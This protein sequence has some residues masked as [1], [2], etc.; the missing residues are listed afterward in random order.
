MEFKSYYYLIKI[1]LFSRIYRKY[2][3]AYQ[4][5]SFRLR[6]LTNSIKIFIKIKLKKE[7]SIKYD[8]LCSP[9]TYGDF[10]VVLAFCRFLSFFSKNTKLMIVQGNHR[11]DWSS[12]SKLDRFL[13][14]KD[15]LE[16]VHLLL[17]NTGLE[18]NVQVFTPNLH[19]HNHVKSDLS[20]YKIIPGI[21]QILAF[22]FRKNIP[23]E[24][25][26]RKKDFLLQEEKK[27][28][29]WHVRKG[30]WEKERNATESQLIMDYRSLRSLFPNHKIV[31][32]SSKEGLD[33]T[34]KILTSKLNDQE[35][36]K[37]HYAIERQQATSYV[38]CIPFLVNCDFYFQR[39]G[40]GLGEVIHLTNVSHLIIE[41]FGYYVFHSKVKTL[42]WF[43]QY[44]IRTGLTGQDDPIKNLSIEEI[45]NKFDINLN[46]NS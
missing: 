6:I 19:N 15:Q 31:V 2:Q 26:L 4:Y 45:L 21:L 3:K 10:F 7:I 14:E 17:E 35:I 20:D 11:E 30:V 40:G 33:F 25:F 28:I 29:A 27:Y 36:I 42:P 32:F 8:N 22:L 1:W 18:K 34:F 38:Q 41:S 16:L 12:L 24:F 46:L 37:L 43:N 9:P 23:E 5:S 39:I 44:Q 13:L